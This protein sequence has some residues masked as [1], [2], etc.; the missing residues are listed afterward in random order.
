[1][2]CGTA[3]WAGFSRTDADANTQLDI[4]IPTPQI[5]IATSEADNDEGAS[6][7]PLSGTPKE[8]EGM[9][10]GSE[11]VTPGGGGGGDTRTVANTVVSSSTS[12]SLQQ[13]PPLYRGR[14]NVQHAMTPHPELTY[15]ASS[16]LAVPNEVF[17]GYHH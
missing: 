11:A 10:E 6:T 4:Q 3:V 7:R 9:G 12:P 13:F 8:G 14:F 2:I 1:V 5:A 15:K 16:K 17:D